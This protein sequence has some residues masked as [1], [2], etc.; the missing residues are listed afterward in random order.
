MD[1]WHKEVGHGHR[2]TLLAPSTFMTHF[3]EYLQSKAHMCICA[4]HTEHS[5][6]QRSCLKVKVH[7]AWGMG[8]ESYRVADKYL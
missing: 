3:F 5:D 8:E 2:L 4:C 6:D 7:A 1:I